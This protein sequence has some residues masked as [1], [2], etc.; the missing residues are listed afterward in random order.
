MQIVDKRT[1]DILKIYEFYKNSPDRAFD[2]IPKIWFESVQILN[3][4]QPRLF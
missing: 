3:K 4:I 1:S 2:P